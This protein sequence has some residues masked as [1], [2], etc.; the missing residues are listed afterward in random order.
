MH[1]L[2]LA[3]AAATAVTPAPVA[4]T[5]E[6]ARSPGT[7]VQFGEGRTAELY[8]AHRPSS[9]EDKR[10]WLTLRLGEVGLIVVSDDGKTEILSVDKF[11]GVYVN[12]DLYVKG[13]KVGAAPSAAPAA[14]SVATPGPAAIGWL[15][16]ALVALATAFVSVLV[17]TNISKH[18]AR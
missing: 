14:T 7:V 1:S 10:D 3:L 4:S 12:G 9:P 16:L 2:L 13:Q 6:I 11:G 15:Q 5:D 17:S 8:A 18:Q